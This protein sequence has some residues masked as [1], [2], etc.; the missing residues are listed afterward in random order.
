MATANMPGASDTIAGRTQ[1]QPNTRICSP[2]RFRDHPVLERKSGMILW[3]P[4]WSN[5][6][7]PKDVWPRGEIG[8][9]ESVWI[10]ELLDKCVFLSVRDDV[11]HY[12]GSM[13]FDD[14]ASCVTGFNFL[15][16]VVG[17]PTA[18]IGDLDVS[19]LL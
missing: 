12:T 4:Q 1:K 14:P 16:S 6:Y 7:Q 8:T 3:P 15:K 5:A 9:L 2:M 19:D 18:E 17:L 11:F 13:Y 10:H